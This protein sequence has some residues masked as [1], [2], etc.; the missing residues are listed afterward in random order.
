MGWQ[1]RSCHPTVSKSK[2][3]QPST[4]FNRLVRSEDVDA[5]DPSTPTLTVEQMESPDGYAS[6][7]GVWGAIGTICSGVCRFRFFVIEFLLALMTIGYSHNTWNKIRGELQDP[8]LPKNGPG[9]YPSNGNFNLSKFNVLING[10]QQTL[11]EVSV[12]NSPNPNNDKLQSIINGSNSK[13]YWG[14]YRRVG[15][16]NAAFVATDF[17]LA[18]DD[19]L[20]IKILTSRGKHLQHNIGRFRLSVTDDPNAYVSAL[21]RFAFRTTEDPW[22]K[23]AIAYDLIG[24]QEAYDKLLKQHPQAMSENLQ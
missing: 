6:P 14:V 16:R 20:T 11:A 7:H 19:N 24:D 23:L 2:A 21:K 8:S 5:G 10:T 17:E 22:A 13:E 15:Q 18:P 3:V 1:I 9:R 12:S 4:G